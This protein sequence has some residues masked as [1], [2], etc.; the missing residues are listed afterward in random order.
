MVPASGP[1]GIAQLQRINI[2]TT[3][4]TTTAPTTTGSTSSSS[5]LSPP[6]IIL[7]NGHHHQ[8][9]LEGLSSGLSGLIDETGAS[10]LVDETPNEEE[11][12]EAGGVEEGQEVREDEEGEEEE[13]EEPLYVNAKQYNRILKRRMAR[14]KLESEG[15]IPKIR[16]VLF[17]TNKNN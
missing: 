5:S 15:R 12:G 13:E 3:A 8:N 1:N 16:Q 7:T 4:A 6:Q 17:K 9:P 14:A 10:G 2:A 11:T